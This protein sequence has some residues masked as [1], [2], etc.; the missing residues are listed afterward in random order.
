M[1]D[2]EHYKQQKLVKKAKKMARNKAM[3]EGF[4]KKQATALVKRAVK[5]IK[6]K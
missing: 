2:L 3:D 1:S 4:S 5:N 6:S